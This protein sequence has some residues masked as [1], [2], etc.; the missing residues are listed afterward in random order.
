MDDTNHFIG[1]MWYFLRFVG[2]Y[3]RL[4]RNYFNTM[5]QESSI[6]IMRLLLPQLFEK[7][8]LHE[9]RALV[10]ERSILNM[11]IKGEVI[12]IPANHVGILLEGFLTQEEVKSLITPPAVLLHS[13][14]DLSFFGLETSGNIYIFFLI[15]CNCMSNFPILPIDVLFL[16][17]LKQSLCIKK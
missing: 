12:E 4:N 8:A 17:I 7:M 6:V 15:S 1:A 3:M 16:F 14:T 2:A 11:H 13:D 5:I 9:L 10:V